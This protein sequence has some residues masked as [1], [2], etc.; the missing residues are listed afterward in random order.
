[1]SAVDFGEDLSRSDLP[2]EMI[3]K[4]LTAA[5]QQNAPTED[6]LTPDYETV[7]PLEDIH[8]V[9]VIAGSPN[10]DEELPFDSL[11]E[12]AYG[13]RVPQG[14]YPYDLVHT[15]VGTG[16]TFP[17]SGKIHAGRLSSNADTHIKIDHDVWLDMGTGIFAFALWI[18][19]TS[20]GTYGIINKRDIAATLNAGVEFWISGTTINVRISDGTNTAL[21]SGSLAT[22]NNGVKHSVIVNIPASGN[23]E[24][25]IDN[26]S[27]STVSRGSVGNINNTRDLII[28]GRDNAGIIQDQY[29]GDW[30]WLVWKKTEIFNSAQRTDFHTNGILDLRT[31]KDVEVICIPGMNNENSLAN[32]TP[33]LCTPV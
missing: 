12:I 15:T 1:M 17:D 5:Q 10:V 2:L 23:L 4:L 6:D 22:L 30:A 27:I 3:S 26:V 21:L 29:S 19:K 9:D 20:T 32:A 11:Q 18:I 7:S 16:F 28:L 33:A 31:T 8:N 13:M 14:P 25:F 24:L